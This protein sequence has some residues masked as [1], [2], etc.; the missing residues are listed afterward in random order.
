MLVTNVTKPN[1]KLRI[2]VRMFVTK[3]SSALSKLMSLSNKQAFPV[4]FMTEGSYVRL[5]RLEVAITV[6]SESARVR[7][8]LLF[9]KNK[10][11]FP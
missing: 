7:L 8:I 5:C 2:Q 4:L 3:S 9:F 10:T 6:C 1:D 11:G